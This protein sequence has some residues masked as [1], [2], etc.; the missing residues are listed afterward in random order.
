MTDYEYS[1]L[2]L[3]R[4]SETRL[5]TLLSGPSEAEIHINLEVVLLKEHR[6]PQFE[7]LSYIWCSTESPINIFIDEEKRKSSIRRPQKRRSGKERHA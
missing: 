2:N 7:T 3:V 1:R 6:I 4:P 5:L